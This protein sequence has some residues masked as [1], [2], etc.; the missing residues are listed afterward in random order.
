MKSKLKL[1]LR[2]HYDGKAVTDGTKKNIADLQRIPKALEAQRGANTRLSEAVGQATAGQTVAIEAMQR[3]SQVAMQQS[4]VAQGVIAA[5]R[6][7]ATTATQSAASQEKAANKAKAQTTAAANQAEVVQQVATSQKSAA[8]AQGQTGQAIKKT[9]DETRKQTNAN[10]KVAQSDNLVAIAAKRRA[11]SQQQA[12]RV[13]ELQRSATRR[14]V[15]ANQQLSASQAKVA[16]S[17]SGATRQVSAL[18][19]GY[20]HLAITLSG[21]V[22]LGT[23][24]M[25]VR[26]TGAAQLLDT[27]LQGLTDTAQGYNA[28][29]H[30]LFNA[31]DRLNTQYTTL[32]DSYSKIL[33]LQQAGVVTQREGVSILEG[34]ANAAAKTGASNV[35]LEQS[36]FGMTQGMTAGVLR[37]EELNQVTEPLPGLLQRLDKAAGVA[38]GGFRQMV[39]DGRVTS[40]MFKKYLITALEDYAGAAEA[41]EGKINASFA[42]MSNEYQRLIRHYEQPVN[43]AVTG[44]VD[45]LRDG[46]RE[47]RENAELVDGLTTAATGLTIVLGGHLAAGAARAT[48]AFTAQVVAKQ[49]A[50]SADLALAKQNQASAAIEHQRSLQA[51]TYAAHTL[52][53]ARTEQMRT[54]A[55]ARLAAANQRALVTQQALTAATA[56]YT[57][58]ARSASVAAR[59]L[60]AVMGV[61]GGPVGLAVTAGLGVAYF[62][63]QSDNAAQSS[64]TLKTNLLNLAGA[65]DSVNNM[66][67]RN[68]IERAGKRAANYTKLIDRAY[69]KLKRLQTL[70]DNA[71][72]DRSKFVYRQQIE[73]TQKYINEQSKLRD[74]QLKL[75]AATANTNK[76]LAQSPWQTVIEE[77]QQAAAALPQNIQQLQTSLLDEEGR[78]QASYEKRRAMVI[79]ARDNDQAN[80]AKYNA[81]LAQLDAKHAEDVKAITTRREAEKTRIQN[82]AEEKRRNDL[83]TELENR[84]AQMRGFSGREA[85]AAYNNELAVEQA[86]QQARVDAKRRGQLGL[87]A[88]D[89]IGELKHN[90]DN[91]IREI[92]RQQELLAAQG[93]HSQREANEA[94][95]QERLMQIRTRHTGALQSTILAFANFEKQTQAEKANAVVGLGANMFKQL[96]GQSKTA[97]K[98]YKAFAISQALINTYQA[99]TGAY[100]ALAPIPIVGPALGVA[101][102]AAAVLSGLQQVRQIKAQQ[103]AGIAHGGLDYVPNESTYL[104]QRGERV[105]SP[106]QNI[107]I[108]AMARHYNAG[109]QSGGQGNISF[110]ITNQITV[111][112]A[113]NDA[114]G[115]LVA[116]NIASRIEAVVIANV[117]SNGS[118]IRAI[119]AA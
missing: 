98:A 82:Q 56:N 110:A 36:L 84:I 7:V 71:G 30:Y 55:V 44:V 4:L 83:R 37:A 32:A 18:N 67:A 86:R 57:V 31:A 19:T 52:N 79:T 89:E 58:A 21:L 64:K 78:L 5:N 23:G 75:A 103:P 48:T 45:L 46:M 92:E 15:A 29:Q 10:Q 87:A 3:G 26:D 96:A 43:F 47:L 54:A 25:F 61:F 33:N 11:A 49:R 91:E 100:T 113:Q 39:N 8:A 74:E 62:A 97:F 20:S 68:D 72:S 60:S 118:I 116:Q 104:L 94:A 65:Y 112:A 28:V 66:T 24:A 88:N 27:R 59:G 108:S 80:K 2:L 6:D 51:K 106:K 9:T 107:E 35:Q 119:K 99:A 95:H 40:Q 14:L 73:Q 50:L 117:R 69:T 63:M 81:L 70:R 17:H 34:M 12:A 90:T 85:L 102:A 38:A 115:E 76:N 41:T 53:V 101:A 16:A 105:L 77:A 111:Q 109:G 13:Q 114:K 22:G 42:E 1:A 93:F